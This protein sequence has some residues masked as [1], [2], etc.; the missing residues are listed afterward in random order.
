MLVERFVIGQIGHLS[1][2]ALT[3]LRAIRRDYYGDDLSWLGVVGPAV[4]FHRMFNFLAV[5][6]SMVEGNVG[7][8][9]PS[10]LRIVV[11]GLGVMVGIVA[12]LVGQVRL[13]W[14]GIEDPDQMM[15]RRRGMARR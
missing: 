3:A 14:K 6:G 4:M 10:N 5:S 15:R 2:A 11:P 8:I 1:A 12:T 9:H 13:E 7:W